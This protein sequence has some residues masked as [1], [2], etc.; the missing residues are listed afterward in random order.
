MHI[1]IFD[2]GPTFM[3]SFFLQWQRAWMRFLPHRVSV[4]RHIP[5]FL[6]S[7]PE[8][9]RGRV[10]ELGAGS[11]ATSR[12]ILDTFPQVE[13]TATDIDTLSLQT[14]TSLSSRYGRRLR[15]EQA[16]VTR[17]PFD[18]SSYDLILAI[19]V[20]WELQGEQ[21]AEA[22]RQMIRVS[23]PFGLIGISQSRLLFGVSIDYDELEKI[24][25]V[26]GCTIL[27]VKKGRYVDM[28][29]QCPNVP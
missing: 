6:K 20:L 28:W 27:S 14:L 11:G 21:L 26:E 16:D 3:M 7:C 9:I 24:L 23:H 1:F 10:L 5:I 15:V 29:V 8:P 4:R 19:N 17:L 22:V 2:F 13:L 12:Q 18:R 25:V